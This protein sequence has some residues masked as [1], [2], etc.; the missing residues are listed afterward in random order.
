MRELASVI[1]IPAP[2]VNEQDIIAQIQKRIPQRQAEAKA[3]GLDYERLVE[4]AATSFSPAL[5]Y[6]LFLARRRADAVEV[7]LT[8]EKSQ[9]PIIGGLLDRFRL[10]LH[11]LVVYYVNRSAGRQVVFNLAVA[12]ALSQLLGELEE[13]EDLIARLEDEAASLR[14]RLE[15]L[16]Q[17]P[18]VEP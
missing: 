4:G 13:R 1:E 9:V 15:L 17:R 5:Y 2:E 8:L 11:R 10:E 6:D 16:E 18:G 14:Q 7:P 12:G 3:Q